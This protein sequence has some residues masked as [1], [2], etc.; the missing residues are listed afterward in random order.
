M[1]FW[2]PAAAGLYY[3]VGREAEEAAVL[4][5]VKIWPEIHG[6]TTDKKE[7]ISQPHKNCGFL[8]KV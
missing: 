8:K 7:A 6:E 5:T 3:I 1:L 4:L 2:N